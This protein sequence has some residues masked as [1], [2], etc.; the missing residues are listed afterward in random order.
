MSSSRRD[1]TAWLWFAVTALVF[2]PAMG[3]EF[4]NWDDKD[5]ILDNPLVTAPGGQAWLDIW[6]H[7]TLGA[8]YP[9]TLTVT[10]LL[11]AISSG[12][13]GW[14]QG[15]AAL[16]DAWAAVGG[17]AAPFHLASILMFAAAA[18][19]LHE[20]LRR[21]GI[22]PAGRALGVVV[23]ALHPL[24]VESVAWAAALRD[25][26]SLDFVLLFVLA[27]LSE[28]P[29]VRRWGAP[30]AFAAAVLCKSMVF[31]LAP[32]PLLLGLLWF[33]RP[34]RELLRGAVAPL[35]VGFAGAAI[36]FLVYRPVAAVND[37]VGGTLLGSIPVIAGVQLR[38]LRLQIAPY[39]L[40]ALP[41]PADGDVLGWFVAAA[42]IA[43]L[44]FAVTLARRGQG[45]LLLACLVYLL[46]MGPVSGLLPL[47][48]PVADRYTLLPSLAV[49]ASVAWLAERPQLNRAI[50]PVTAATALALALMTIF[51]IPRWHDSETLWRHSL[52][53]FP[54]EFGAHQ[55]YAGVVG[56]KGRMKE[57]AFH[58][59]RALELA[60]GKE[61]DTTKLVGL[62]MFAELLKMDV[63]MRRIEPLNAQYDQAGRDPMALASLGVEL[64]AA[65][66]GSPS[67]VI[68]RRAEELGAPPSAISL[69]YAT[70]AAR[71]GE[72]DRVLYHTSVGLEEDPEAQQLLALQIMAYDQL[73]ELGAALD[74]ADEVARQQYTG[75]SA[76][77]IVERLRKRLP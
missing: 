45:R 2:L 34:W 58:L 59:T 8:Y 15:N 56:G 26:L 60:D 74:V 9:I 51:T 50:L 6:R 55:N 12:V 69:G 5:W 75:I 24:R 48:W 7:P 40:A 10:R 21:M 17:T 47:A 28:R 14:V 73:G 32:L 61:P 4:L 62:L 27:S 70:G 76:E 33:R 65:R 63:P 43:L 49:A 64:A 57:A 41:S 39:D 35:V 11:W 46:A 38:Y 22:G 20:C 37:Y 77:G 1:R 29:R 19:L 72:W 31:T 52:T 44:V 30:A 3:G 18:G 36:A 71:G 67:S 42:A 13:D 25:M 68:L 23:F 66:L 16:T 53:R 54:D